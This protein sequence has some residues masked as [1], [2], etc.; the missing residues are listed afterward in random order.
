MDIKALQ[1]RLRQAQEM[2]GYF[3]NAD[4]EQV[5]ALLQGLLTNK[6][7][8][9]YMSCPCRLA[10]GDRHQDRDILCLCLYRQADVEQYGSCYCGLYVSGPWNEGLIP[11]VH[12]PERRSPA[13]KRSAPPL[14]TPGNRHEA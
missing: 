11:H 1:D 6:Q 9:G 2:L 12:V 3:F 4:Q 10:T 13:E 5:E 7:R 14:G 8:Y